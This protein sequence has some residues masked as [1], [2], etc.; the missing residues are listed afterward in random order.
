MQCRS[1]SLPNKPFMPKNR[2][3][4]IVQ[5]PTFLSKYI[6]IND[7]TS[8]YHVTM[9]LMNKLEMIFMHLSFQQN[10][11]CIN[12]LVN[13]VSNVIIGRDFTVHST[14]NLL[15]TLITHSLCFECN[16]KDTSEAL[17]KWIVEKLDWNFL[18]SNI[19]FSINLQTSPQ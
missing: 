2:Y 15:N 3:L 17:Y 12:L 10:V 4:C 1:T 8:Y 9:F 18:H 7:K 13:F 14:W 11:F 5:H 19:H 16:F 6:L